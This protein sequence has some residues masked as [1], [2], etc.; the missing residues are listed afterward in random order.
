MIRRGD[1]VL[2]NLDPTVGSE[3]GKTRPAVVV[4]NDVGNRFSA[5]VIVVAI[6]SYSLRKA[7]FPVCVEIAS[8]EAGLSRRSIANASQ[9]RTVDRARLADA[10]LGRLMVPTMKALDE[11]LRL[12]LAL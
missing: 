9:I 5:T 6:T 10:P 11:A 1:V 3:I 7:T 4:Q 12:S 2:V 8:G